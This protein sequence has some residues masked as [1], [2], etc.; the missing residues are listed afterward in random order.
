VDAAHYLMGGPSPDRPH[1]AA[2]IHFETLWC[3]DCLPVVGVAGAIAGTRA[4]SCL[5]VETCDASAVTLNLYAREIAVPSAAVTDRQVNALRALAGHAGPFDPRSFRGV[6]TRPPDHFG[7]LARLRL[8]CRV[9]ARSGD[10][11]QETA[12]ARLR[13]AALRAGVPPRRLAD[14]VITAAD[15]L[16]ARSA[17]GD[18]PPSRGNPG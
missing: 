11:S 1:G 3:D 15:L 14:V 18:E 13:S 9:L 4:M 2:E 12:A 17:P 6:S 16:A 5:A 8:A 7:D 10:C